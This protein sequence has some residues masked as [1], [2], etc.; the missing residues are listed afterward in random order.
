MAIDKIGGITRSS[1]VRPIVRRLA[2]DP[3]QRDMFELRGCVVYVDISRRRFALRQEN[4]AY[5]VAWSAVTEFIGTDA[6]SMQG[7]EVCVKGRIK[8]EDFQADSIVSVS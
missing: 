8:A 7:V 1:F 4:R 6:A 2:T 5:D 3:V